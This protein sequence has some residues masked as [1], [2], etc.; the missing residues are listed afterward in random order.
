MIPLD[1]NP[2]WTA[3]ALCSAQSRKA[4]LQNRNGNSRPSPVCAGLVAGGSKAPAKR[5]VML[6]NLCESG[7]WAAALQRHGVVRGATLGGEKVVA[8]R[9]KRGGAC[10]I[11]YCCSSSDAACA[12]F[13]NQREKIKTALCTELVAAGSRA[14]AD[15]LAT[16][17]NFCESGSWAAPRES[18][19]R[20]K[21]R[22]CLA[23]FLH[24]WF[25]VNQVVSHL[26]L[27][28]DA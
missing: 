22:S 17:R 15:R 14:P 13:D 26:R 9:G 2:R 24:R 18:G 19:K 21:C 7:S 8:K 20:G 4:I 28:C 11:A 25:A 27:Q 10:L 3:S 23:S 16:P 12:T 1:A 5:L 6:R